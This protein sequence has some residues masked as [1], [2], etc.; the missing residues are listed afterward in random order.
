[1]HFFGGERAPLATPARCGPYTTTATLAP[2][3]ANPPATA[4]SSFAITQGPHGGPC[5]GAALPFSPSLTGGM[6]SNNAG[7]F[8]PLSTTI[9]RGDGQQDMRSV[10]LHMPPGLEGVLSGVAL[11]PEAQANAG[12]CPASSLIG[13][14]TVSAGVG[15]EPVSVEGGRVYLTEGYAGAPFGLSIVNPVKAGPFDLEHDTANPA[16]QPAC[17][18]LV[19]R[20]KIEVDPHTAE[21]TVSTDPSGAHAIPHL[22]DGVPVQIQKVNV[23]IGREHFTFNPTNCAPLAITGSISAY[24]GASVPLSVPFQ[25]T[26]CANL[27]FTPKF[28]VATA[29]KTTKA[30]GASLS[31]KLS[32]PKAPPGTYANLAKVKVSLPKQLPSRLTTLQKACTAASFDANPA[33]CPKES[34]VGQAKVS[35]P[36]LPVALSGPAYFVSH[37][38]EAFPDLTIVLQG[39][40]LTIDLVGSTQ[41]KNGIT[42]STF[43][44]TPDV[45]FDSFQLKLPQGKFS[46][47]AANAN[48][49]ASKLRMPSEFTAQNGAVLRQDTKIAVSGCKLTRHQRLLKALRHCRKL[50]HAKARRKHCERAA[51]RRYGARHTKK[52]K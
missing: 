23:R 50:H 27:K 5:P 24:E 7:A 14:T 42:T 30:S 35:T 22:I 37:G 6:T 26:N 40:G 1:M 16:N 10:T 20:A 48:L 28:E 47:L 52:R 51:R 34:I 2:W 41:I 19:V 13:E 31:V 46:A 43:K 33:S 25:A 32:Y 17:D 44:S 3:S 39:Y 4:S 45:P 36:V 49:C 29:G 11:C 18:C 12:S 9:G 38:G 15:S 21:L 8:S